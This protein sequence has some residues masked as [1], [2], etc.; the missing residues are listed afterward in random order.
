MS[1]NLEDDI[2]NYF[3]NP[4]L[5]PVESDSPDS[6]IPFY[7]DDEIDLQP[8]TSSSNSDPNYRAE[9]PSYTESRESEHE[10]LVPIPQT[11]YSNV[12]NGWMPQGSSSTVSYLR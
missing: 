6:A 9:T 10:T 1:N 12:P 8:Y 5:A 3:H 7:Q 11:P 4:Y 2:H